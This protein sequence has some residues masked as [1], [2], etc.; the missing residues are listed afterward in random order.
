MNRRHFVGKTSI[1]AAGILTSANSCSVSV[2]GKSIDKFGFQTYTV[3][4]QVKDRLESTLE[5]IAGFGY[6]YAELYGLYGETVLGH[7][8][9]SV[10][11]AY[12]KAGIEMRSA[13]CM[14]G[15]EAP[16]TKGTMQND[17]QM[18]VD[19]AST[20]GVK[21]VVCA[22]LLDQERKTIDD[23]KRVAE[24]LNKSAEVAKKSGIQMGYHNHEFEFELLE[25]Q[26]P[27][28]VLMNETDPD[29]VKLE[30]DIYWAIKA[31]KDPIALF[32]KYK[33]RVNLWH[34]KDMAKADSEAMTE[35][36]LGRIDW[37]EIFKNQNFQE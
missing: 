6:G 14:T 17:W 16:E 5:Q 32:E 12:N 33:G 23:Y 27:L 37:Q 19:A 24:L 20:L 28:E 34:V 2:S 21:H 7:P 29:L 36:G 15:T 13:H 11:D 9:M 26:E 10:K 25:G 30:L 8:I 4:N 22:Y 3:R 18:A 1:L 31:K 35:V